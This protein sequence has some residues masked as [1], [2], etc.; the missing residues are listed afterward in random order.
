MAAGSH[1]MITKAER[2]FPVRIRV[3]LPP[4]GLGDRIN[5]MLSAAGQRY[6]RI[7]RS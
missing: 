2:R 1:L 5:A 6:T 7:N 3:A 4:G